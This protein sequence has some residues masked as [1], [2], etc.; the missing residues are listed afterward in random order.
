ML[1]VATQT[2]L[3]IVKVTLESIAKKEITIPPE[4]LKWKT[5][6]VLFLEICRKEIEDLVLRNQSFSFIG[7]LHDSAQSLWVFCNNTRNCKQFYH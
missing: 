3:Q 7:S 1:T 2:H 6:Q 5:N 4:K